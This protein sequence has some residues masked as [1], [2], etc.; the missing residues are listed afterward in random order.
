[1]PPGVV[2]KLVV[3]LEHRSWSEF[4]TAQ[5]TLKP[6][7]WAFTLG[8]S[9]GA[10]VLA[11]FGTGFASSPSPHRKRSPSSAK[12]RN[13]SM[14]NPLGSMKGRKVDRRET[15]RL[16]RRGP[17]RPRDLEAYVPEPFRRAQVRDH[18][19]RGR[20]F[21]RALR[22]D[23]PRF[24]VCRAAVGAAGAH[25]RPGAGCPPAVYCDGLLPWNDHCVRGQCPSGIAAD[26]DLLPVGSVVRVENL[27]AAYNGIYTV[28]DTGPKVHGR[29]LDIYIW[30]CDEALELGR[31]QMVIT[32][33]RMGWNPRNST[34][35]LVDDL[36]RQREAAPPPPAWPPPSTDAASRPLEDR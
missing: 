5:L 28:M 27:P 18:F 8:S 10:A 12:H 36:F 31:R 22:G 15:R 13:V 17:S 20:H 34:P 24:T 7:L 25:R 3:G 14:C 19:N 4:R 6:F 16:E 35:K 30:N 32:V 29:H 9:V 1:M 26:P 2:E 33:L 11:L 23:G 21:R